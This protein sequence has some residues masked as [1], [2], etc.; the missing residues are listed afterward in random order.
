LKICINEKPLH[1]SAAAFFVRQSAVRAAALNHVFEDEIC[2]VIWQMFLYGGM[3]YRHG[4]EAYLFI[5]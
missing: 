2:C 4:D 5:F 1:E 3:F